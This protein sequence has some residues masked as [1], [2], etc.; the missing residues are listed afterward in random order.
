MGR[1]GVWED[2]GPDCGGA[3]WVGVEVSGGHLR[4]VCV[5]GHV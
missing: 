3:L 2:V 1:G 4:D 5:R